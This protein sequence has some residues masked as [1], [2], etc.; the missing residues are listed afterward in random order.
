VQIDSPPA[1]RGAAAPAASVSVAALRVLGRIA[2][3]L[4][5]PALIVA[6]WQ[7][8]VVAGYLP[9]RLMPSPLKVATTAYDFVLGNSNS[10]GAYAFS[11][12][13]VKHAWVSTLRVLQGFSL[14][15]FAGVT[16][17]LLL[18][19]SRT[20][21]R[22]IDP[23][24][25]VIRPI[26]ITAWLPLS[27]MWFGLGNGATLFLIFLG[28]FFPILI[29]T[30]TGVK[31]VDRRLIEAAEML[32]TRR[33]QLFYRVLLPGSLPSILAGLR[34]GLGFAWVCLVV[35]E[36]TG[37][38]TGL[39]SAIADARELFRIDLI[40]VGMLLIGLIGYAS[41][42]LVVYG[43]RRALRWSPDLFR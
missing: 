5:V 3:V 23:V 11:G 32:G 2:R 10:P 38:G 31:V 18:G 4:A 30:T 9:P 28:A 36:M 17:G 34:V 41:D 15:A 37:V 19:V 42:R 35:G 14:A 13:F 7:G 27:I 25:Q 22:F 8:A 33:R 16:L 20:L 1:V 12:S 6:A 26:P 21:E 29:N 39:G 24:L 40:I 43:F